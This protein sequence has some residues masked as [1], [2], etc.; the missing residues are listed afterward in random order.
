[1]K[2]NPKKKLKFTTNLF[3]YLISSPLSETPTEK[4]KFKFLKILNFEK[5]FEKFSTRA[6]ISKYFHLAVAAYSGSDP[7]LIAKSRYK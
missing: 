3:I 5:L 7:K 4:N 6:A 1:M 2:H